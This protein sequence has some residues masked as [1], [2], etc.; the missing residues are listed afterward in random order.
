MRRVAR[1][2]MLALIPTSV[3][4]KARDYR[5]PRRI[6]HRV[7]TTTIMCTIT[8][9]ITITTLAL[10]HHPLYLNPLFRLYTP[11][12]ARATRRRAS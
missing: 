6:L 8:T 3:L 5:I 9:T 4:G 2:H 12:T 10:R 1:C 7:G 11:T